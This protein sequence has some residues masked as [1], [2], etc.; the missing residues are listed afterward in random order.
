M[1]TIDYSQKENWCKLPEITKEVDTFYNNI[2]ANVA[3]RV[4]AYLSKK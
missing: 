2:K 4:D 3:K 1:N